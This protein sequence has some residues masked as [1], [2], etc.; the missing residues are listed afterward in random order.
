M[1]KFKKLKTKLLVL[2]GSVVLISLTTSISI[3]TIKSSSMAK[4]AAHETAEEMAYHY[5][6]Y[7][8]SEI[9]T[10]MDTARTV[11]QTFEG[12]KQSG[13]TD[14]E[15]ANNILKH[16][17]EKNSKFAGVWTCW[18]PNTFDGRD[19]E[20]TN[21]V[22]H[23]ETGRF[24]PYWS[25][26]NGNI[27]VVPLKD[28]KIPGP[29]DY[30][31]LTKNT[32]KEVIT[33]PYYYE[34]GGTQVLMTSLVVPIMI[35]GKFIGVAGI[36]F[37]L[38]TL[39]KIIAEIKPFETGYAALIANNGTYVGH[40]DSVQVGND[41]GNTKEF[42]KIKKAIK[43]GNIYDT[44]IK[45][46]F[47]NT[48]VHRIF[49]PINI[50]ESKT[51]WSFSISVPANKILEK[52][53]EIRNY[54][55]LIGII[56]IAVVLIVLFFISNS[57]VRPIDKTILMLKDIAQGEGDL[58]K[59]LEIH[60][61]DEI[62]ELANW[63]NLFV[64]KIQDLVGQVKNNAYALA[65]SSNQI[66]LVMEQSNNGIE[67]ISKSVNDVSDSFQNN[68]SIVEETTASIEEIASSTALIS[69]E[70]EIAFESSNHILDSAN[71]GA[72]HIKEIVEV[73]NK[74]K[75]STDDVYK[76]VED[77]KVS[78]NHIGEIVSII[79]GISQQ[80]NLLALNASI[81][82]ARAGEHGKGFAV[83]AEEVRKLAEESKESTTKITTLINEIQKKSE[84][85]DA[86]I[87]EGQQF[88]KISVEKADDT[89]SEFENILSAIKEITE[90][91]EM[92]SNSSKQQTQIS[93]D[94]AKAMDEISRTT[95]DNAGEVQQINAVVEEQVSSFE[96]ITA[97]IDELNNTA[98]V[99]KEYTDKFKVE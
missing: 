47:L 7:V 22:G 14:R 57:I 35:E 60:T 66:A 36:D 10:A 78:S 13:S 84:N 94:M 31:L 55:V 87:K 18:E 46:T 92:M 3:G 39:Q 76:T 72:K 70:A 81:E 2:I 98:K 37:T 16:I 83:V 51:P 44:T 48:D 69:G 89:N 99:L 20:F 85:A 17:L 15:F 38:D 91:I 80:T 90:K 59:K 65:A 23:D 8:L 43:D 93:E 27:T 97:S 96:E 52:P 63:F 56:A 75:E 53:N 11:A 79:S 88:V 41:I 30:Y 49:V 58:T 5:G 29:G 26:D 86:A 40:L 6:N 24:V 28:Y 21:K 54:S 12:M 45:S 95:L 67:D 50:G 71:I 61:N 34:M 62:E 9:A 1:F 68:A 33:D 82:A 19:K 42:T 73:I 77:L 74:V 25:K 64:S 4:Q 32:K